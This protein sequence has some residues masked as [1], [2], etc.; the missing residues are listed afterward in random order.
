[1]IIGADWVILRNG[2]HLSVVCCDSCLFTQVVMHWFSVSC[3]DS[4]VLCRLVCTFCLLTPTSDQW[5][6]CG[7][8]LGVFCDKTVHR[9]E[10]DYQSLAAAARGCTYCTSTTASRFI[11]ITE[12]TRS[13]LIVSLPHAESRPRG[14]NDGELHKFPMTTEHKLL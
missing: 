8:P 14:C 4:P 1:M 2:L 7:Q 6:C 9:S 11:V 12:S 3:V 13:L 10:N 5:D